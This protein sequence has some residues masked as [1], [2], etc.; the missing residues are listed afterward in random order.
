VVTRQRSTRL[1]RDARSAAAG[2]RFVQGAVTD[3]LG[4]SAD[5]QLME[6]LLVVT[7]EL[8]TNAVIHGVGP[9]ELSVSTLAEG[10]EVSVS[11]SG[12]GNP[13]LRP[14]PASEE[15]GRGLMLVAALV[16]DWGVSRDPARP[17]TTT[18]WVRLTR[19]R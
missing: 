11:D 8:L 1:P 13:R 7:S 2:R 6:D 10:V 15:G 4:P 18:V 19:K 16:D 9:I 5:G 3:W 12:G 14:G 17:G